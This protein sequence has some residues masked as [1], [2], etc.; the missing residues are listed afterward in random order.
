MSLTSQNRITVN[1][2][3]AV[4]FRGTVLAASV[5][6]RHPAKCAST[7]KRPVTGSRRTRRPSAD[8]M[9][10]DAMPADQTGP[11]YWPH[12]GDGLPPAGRAMQEQMHPRLWASLVLSRLVRG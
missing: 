10:R 9:R 11:G 5:A 4:N 12:R 2:N 6:H 7:S 8:S 1:Q 3:R